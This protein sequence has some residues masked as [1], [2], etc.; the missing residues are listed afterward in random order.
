MRDDRG[1]TTPEDAGRY[2]ARRGMADD[3]GRPSLAE[4]ARDECAHDHQHD[5]EGRTVWPPNY[6]VTFV[7]DD[8]GAICDER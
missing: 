5:L 2:E 8:C 6:D 7:C 1:T 3:P 4:A